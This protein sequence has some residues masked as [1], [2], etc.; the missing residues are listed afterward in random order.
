MNFLERLAK[1]AEVDSIGSADMIAKCPKAELRE[2]N[3][4]NVKACVQASLMSMLYSLSVPLTGFPGTRHTFLHCEEDVQKDPAV[5]SG[6]R[7][8][9]APHNVCQHLPG[10]H[11]KRNNAAVW[12]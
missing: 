12:S 8:W 7:R 3:H 11:R 2:H 1:K 4:G 9:Q 5:E 6:E 10:M